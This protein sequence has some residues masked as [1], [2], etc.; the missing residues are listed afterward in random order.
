MVLEGSKGNQ[1]LEDQQVNGDGG[2][3]NDTSHFETVRQ[4]SA[5]ALKRFCGLKVN[6]RHDCSFSIRV[7]LSAAARAL[8]GGNSSRWSKSLLITTS[9]LQLT[10]QSFLDTQGN[11]DASTIPPFRVFTLQKREDTAQ[12]L[13][14]PA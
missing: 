11:L 10:R 6:T 12:W 1:T 13:V 5:A 2:G 14:Q 7:A 9:R 3:G 4:H 8:R